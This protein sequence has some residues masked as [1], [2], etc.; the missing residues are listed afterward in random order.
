MEYKECVLD[1]R[2]GEFVEV[3]AGD[4]MTVTEF[5]EHKGVTSRR[6]RAVLRE[7]GFLYIGGGRAHNRHHL[8]PWVT[9]GGFGKHVPAKPPRVRYPFDVIGPDGREWIEARWDE[10]LARMQASATKPV[11]EE[12]RRALMSFR[13]RRNEDLNVQ[14]CVLWLCDH[15]PVLTH[16]EMGRILDVTQQLVSRYVSI[17]SKQ[18]ASGLLK[19]Q[20]P[21]P[22]LGKV[23]VSVTLEDAA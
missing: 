9:Q 17:R 11:V 2:S 4:W 6:I 16:T 7:M 15:Y 22:D 8:M 23:R 21:L 5:G 1:R 14:G 10:T 19:K 20:E 3:S 12:A 13:S 18:R